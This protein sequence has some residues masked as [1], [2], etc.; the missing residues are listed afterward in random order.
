MCIADKNGAIPRLP[1]PAM[2]LSSKAGETQPDIN[3]VYIECGAGAKYRPVMRGAYYAA[4]PMGAVSEYGGYTGVALVNL[5]DQVREAVCR[6]RRAKGVASHVQV[7]STEGLILSEERSDH[8]GVV[9]LLLFCHRVEVC[10]G[11]EL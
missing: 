4:T 2:M 9:C 3:V 1:P 6:W 8:T 11:L 5:Q 10:S 7:C